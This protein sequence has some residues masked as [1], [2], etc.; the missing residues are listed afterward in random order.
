MSLSTAFLDEIRSRTSLSGLIGQKVKLEKKGKEHKGCCPFH[1]EK[2]PSFTVNDDKEFYHCFGCGAHG[3][4]L[5][6]LTDH[7]GMDFMDAVKQLAA[8]AGLEMPARSAEEAERARRVEHVGQVLGE[9]ADWYAQQL[10]PAGVAMEALAAR[11]IEGAAI[12]RFGL[13]FAPARGGISAIGIA[14]DQL[15]AAGL[16]VEDDQGKRR[17]RFRHRIMV[18]IHD[19]RGRPIGFGG[20]AFGEA[21]PKYLNSDQSEHFD[22]GRVLFNLHRAAP[23]ARVAR[24]LLVVEGY[25][26]AIALDQA[27]I[28]EVVAPMGTAITPE[29]LERAWRV[30]ECPV[31]LMDGD[32]AG[33][34]AANRACVRALP[35]AGPGRSLKIATLPDGHDPDSLVRECGREAID[36]VIASGLSLSSYVWTAV[37]AAGDRAT[38]EGRAAIWQQLADLAA[39]VQ[40]EE[41]RGQYQAYWRGLFNAEFPP[42]PRWVVE[43]QKLPVGTMEAKFSDQAA[44]VQDRLKAVAAKRLIGMIDAAERT[45]DGVTLFAWGMGR[46]VGAGLIDQ[47]AADDAI[48]EV[49]D[50]VDDVTSDDIERSFAA[51][52]AKGFDIAPMLLD[53]RCAGFQRTDLGNAERFNARYGHSF[54]FTTAKGWL[55]WD[56]RRWK[57]LDQ[58]KDTLPAEVQ[59]AVFDTVRSIQREADFVATTGF[60]EPSEP[61][62]EEGK[63]PLLLVWQW[64]MFRDSGERIGAMD[65]V[66]E[67]KSG[68]VI[69]SELIGKWGRASEGSGR[70]GCIAGLAKRWVTA[71]IEDFDRDPLAINVL[72]GTL[73]FRRDKEN[74]S[75]VTLEPHRRED[76]NTKLAPVTYDPEASSI[77]YDGFFAWAQPDPA[78][79]RYLHQWAGY[80]ASGDIS[81]Q[82]LQFWYGLG[83]NGKSVTIDLWAYVLGDYSGTIGIETFLDQ[84]IKKRGEQ[85]SPDLAR[86]GG[87]RMLRASEPE[88]GAKLNEA[89]IKAATGGEPMAVRALHRG[90]FDLMPLFKLTIGGNYKPDIPGTDEG[91]WRRMKLV[92]WNAHVLEQDRDEQLP[93]KLRAEAAGVLNHMVRGLLDWLD[94]GL[95]EPEAVREATAQYREDSDPLARFLKLCTVTDPHERIQSSKLYEVF[96]AWCKAA[97]EREWSQKGFSKAMLDKGFQKKA[98]DGMQ[99]L[100]MKLVREAADF[101]DEHGKVRQDVPM[102]P[103]GEQSAAAPPDA[104]QPPPEMDDDFVPGF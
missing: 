89:L 102:L 56:G 23:A 15:M 66:T 59:A 54:R 10:E 24:R 18:P 95:V 57:V 1:S 30:T 88:R 99:W 32:E 100:G 93:A 41:T 71:P 21:Q 37:L 63:P 73:R 5:R 78:M 48:E 22:K 55:G 51:G 62:P 27:G 20:R 28:E 82:K 29:Q 94:N 96:V 103:D 53:M 11:G 91:I 81:E 4:A 84:G 9:A 92:P 69:L 64:K 101:V 36:D 49:A 76:L 98:S 34:K 83:G 35:M 7:E 74:G 2:T 60:V 25:F 65:R 43:D 90:F 77:V 104:D 42:A 31:L 79:R 80:S 58:D 72:N 61:L 3:D 47:D 68:P 46:R 6:W 87:V 45:K 40:H 44:E 13:G 38:P 97:G 85:A 67:L 16:I 14:V 50:G 70:L 33:R 12:A 26:D 39:T 52:V 8:A 17:D 19:A 75:T 86:L